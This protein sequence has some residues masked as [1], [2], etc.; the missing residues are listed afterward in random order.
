MIQLAGDL[1]DLRKIFGKNKSDASHCSG[2]VK[3]APDN[4][5]LFI[6][7]VTMSGY[8]TMNRILKFYKFAF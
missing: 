2:L 3:L 1:I 8:E 4:A 5:D 6:A 7:H